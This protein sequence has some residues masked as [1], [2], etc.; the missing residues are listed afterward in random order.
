LRDRLMGVMAVSNR[1]IYSPRRGQVKNG[2]VSG[3]QPY[4][5]G[6]SLV[7]RGMNRYLAVGRIRD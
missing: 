1:G 3:F 5:P 7:C 2:K 4:L 6:T